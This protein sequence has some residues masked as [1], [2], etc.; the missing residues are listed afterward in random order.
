V[1][2]VNKR[3][4]LGTSEQDGIATGSDLGCITSCTGWFRSWLHYQ[5]Y[6][7]VQTLAALPAV[8]AGSDLDRITSYT[9]RV[10]CVF[11]YSAQCKHP[12]SLESLYIT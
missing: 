11:P 2:I 1:Q 10:L 3:L 6:W 7:L 9:D 12:G 4:D 5:L 8:L